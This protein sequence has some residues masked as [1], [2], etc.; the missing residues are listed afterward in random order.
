MCLP[1]DLSSSTMISLQREQNTME[2][3]QFLSP[4]RGEKARP[5]SRNLLVKALTSSP[6][7]HEEAVRGRPCSESTS[8]SDVRG[9]AE[10]AA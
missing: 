2:G 10:E 4:L 9:R 6:A 7:D 3:N 5:R 8:P 1:Q